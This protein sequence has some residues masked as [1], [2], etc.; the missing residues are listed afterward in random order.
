MTEKNIRHGFLGAGICPLDVKKPLARVI[1]TDTSPQAESPLRAP[2]R[3]RVRDNS[4]FNTPTDR[5]ELAA[6]L[7]SLKD[8]LSTFKRRY[9]RIATRTGG[10]LERLQVEN[11]KLRTENARLKASSESQKPT[12]KKAVWLV[13]AKTSIMDERPRR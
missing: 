5:V 11:V 10:K 13:A 3:R 8:D 7:N 12:K 6:Q 9:Q 1:T 4:N 2:K